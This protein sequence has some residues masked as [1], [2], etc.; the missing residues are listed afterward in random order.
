MGEV[1]RILITGAGGF[2]GRATLAQARRRGLEVVAVVRGHVPGEWASDPGIQVLH[3]DMADPSCIPALTSALENCGGAIHA[4]AHLGGDEV[5]IKADTLRATAHLLDA[6]P[7]EMPLVLV[8]SIAVYDTMALSPGDVLDESAPLNTETTAQ[9]PYSR[10]KLAQETLCRAT[11]RPL[12][13]IRPGAVYGSG[14]SW[15]ALN[16]FWAGPLL[17]RIDSAGE[18]PLCHVTHL[19]RTLVDAAVTAP[20]GVRMVNVIDD[21]RPTRARFCATHKRLSGWPRAMLPVP[22][23]LWL[24]LARALSPVRGNLPGL[25]REPVLRARMMP[26]RYPNTALRSALGGADLAPFEEMLASSVET[27]A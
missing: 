1:E 20:Q 15:H 13:L 21:D 5:A 2:I 17:V 16:G 3:A 8:S 23:G 4:A 27:D 7:E 9:D 14:R 18:L 10:A 22:Y 11:D 24:D 25:L 26:L 19:G 12:W 6:L